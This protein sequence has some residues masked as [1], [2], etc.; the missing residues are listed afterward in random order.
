MKDLVLTIDTD[1]S[2]IVLQEIINDL[3]HYDQEQAL[4]AGDKL[5]TQTRN[6]TVASIPTYKWYVGMLWH[7]ISRVNQQHLNTLR[8]DGYIVATPTGSTAYSLSGGGPILH[9]NL[10]AIV[11]VPICPHTLSNRPIVIDA[12]SEI[13]ILLPTQNRYTALA[14]VDGQIN[15]DFMPGDTLIIEKGEFEL[16]LIQPHQYDYFEVLREKLRWSTT[17]NNKNK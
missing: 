7:Y 15:M 13:E 6:C 10:D 9:P 11:L 8:A 16:R 14:S 2:N 4:T 3:Q 17:H 12:E 1:I 5:N